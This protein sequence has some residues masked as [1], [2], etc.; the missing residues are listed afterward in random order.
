MGYTSSTVKNRYN[1]KAYKRFEAQLK[2]EFYEELDKFC[3][4]NGLSKPEFLKL[5]FETLK[6]R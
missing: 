3:K 6:N 4:D 2:P 5:A 1:K